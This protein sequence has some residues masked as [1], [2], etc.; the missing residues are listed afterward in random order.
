MPDVIDVPSLLARQMLDTTDD[1]PLSWTS[2]YAAGEACTDRLS[3]TAAKNHQLVVMRRGGCSFSEKL[4]NIPAHAPGPRSL[5]MVVVVSDDFEVDEKTGQKRQLVPGE[6]RPLLDQV[7]HTPGGMPRRMPISM[8][9]VHGGEEAY[10]VLSGAASVGM[11]RRYMVE[12]Q[13]KPIKNVV[14]F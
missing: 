14:L 3:D 8:V 1:S 2:I 5:Q 6:V 4:A 12:S 7:Q 11:R 9:M 10:R 13:G